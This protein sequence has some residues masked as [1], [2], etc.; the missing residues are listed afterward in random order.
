MGINTGNQGDGIIYVFN[1]SEKVMSQFEYLFSSILKSK[2]FKYGSDYFRD[3]AYSSINSTYKGIM[4]CDYLIKYNN[5]NIYIEI[6]GVIEAYKTW[7]YENKTIN[8]SKTK[9]N[10]RIKLMEKEQLLKDSNSEYYFI[11]PCDITSENL[12]AILNKTEGIKEKIE[13]FYYH[14]IN[15]HEVIKNGKLDYEYVNGKYKI[16]YNS[17]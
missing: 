6:P 3:V 9:E 7:Y 11:F 1:D 8:S 15:W 17:K 14:N 4:N 10:Y 13:S 5:R 2:G 12:D 16:N